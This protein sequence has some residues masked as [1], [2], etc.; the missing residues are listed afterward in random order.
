MEVKG[1]GGTQAGDMEARARDGGRGWAPRWGYV[2]S[3]QAAS[4]LERLLFNSILGGGRG[5]RICTHSASLASAGLAPCLES[6][7]RREGVGGSV[8]GGKWRVGREAW[9]G[10]GEGRKRVDQGGLGGAVALAVALPFAA[11]E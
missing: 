2:A 6:W 9:R 3:E 11:K 7:P 4:L 8:H 1:G 5:A 10:A